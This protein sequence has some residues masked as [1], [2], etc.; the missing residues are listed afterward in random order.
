MI[1]LNKTSVGH[2]HRE[3]TKTVQGPQ[4]VSP[5]NFSS[6]FQLLFS[7]SME[8]VSVIKMVPACN[9]SQ[10]ASIFPITSRV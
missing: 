1:S 10:S 9:L 4:E 3:W 5:W 8:R 6:N 7:F 2:W